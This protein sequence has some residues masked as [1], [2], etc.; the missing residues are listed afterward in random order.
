MALEK[1]AG[2]KPDSRKEDEKM[3]E[4]VV[5]IVVEKVMEEMD[6]DEDDSAEPA[7]DGL[8]GL[9]FQTVM[10]MVADEAPSID[11][12]FVSSEEEIE[13]LIDENGEFILN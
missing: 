9:I 6:S 5:K 7:S 12:L 3:I 8:E 2:N 10:E 13:E 4:E 1:N 11:D